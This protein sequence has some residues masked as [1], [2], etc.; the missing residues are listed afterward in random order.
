MP[1]VRGPTATRRPRRSEN[2]RIGDC[3]RTMKNSGPADP[4]R[5]HEA[6]LDLTRVQA[7]GVFRAGGFAFDDLDRC[8]SRPAFEQRLER[9]ALAVEGAVALGSADPDRHE[10]E[11]R[12]FIEI[13]EPIFVAE[14]VVGVS[15]PA[16]SADQHRRRAR[17]HCRPR[18]RRLTK[19]VADVRED[20]G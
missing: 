2:D 18:G 12:T 11:P 6:E 8:Q 10:E 7:I 20:A 13:A 14:A 3:A 17:F 16:V 9:A 19:K 1:L 4:V 15:S 5:R